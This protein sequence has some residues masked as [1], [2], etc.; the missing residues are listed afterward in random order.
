MSFLGDLR[1]YLAGRP[2]VFALVGQNIFA[3]NAPQGTSR[4]GPHIIYHQI[5]GPRDYHLTGASGV[6]DSQYQF[7]CFGNSAVQAQQVAKTIRDAFN[8]LANTTMGDSTIHWCAIEGEQEIP[9][10]PKDG[11]DSWTYQV[12]VDV[13]ITYEES[14][15]TFS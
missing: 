15:P 6:V 2:A 1:S 5:L 13:Q 4:T 3:G 11:S 12:A 8:G 9:S 14:V 10:D 7:S